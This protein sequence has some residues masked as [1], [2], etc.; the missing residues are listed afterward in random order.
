MKPRSWGGGVYDLTKRK[1]ETDSKER[2]WH[3]L[4]YRDNAEIWRLIG[5]KYNLLYDSRLVDKMVLLFA[6]PLFYMAGHDQ[7]ENNRIKREE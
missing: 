6:P 2:R 3:A 5:K 7:R 4:G 1:A